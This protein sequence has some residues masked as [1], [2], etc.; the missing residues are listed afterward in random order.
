MCLKLVSLTLTAAQ[1]LFGAQAPDAWIV[2]VTASD[3]PCV[4]GYKV[5]PYKDLCPNLQLNTK[6][7][8]C[9]HVI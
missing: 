2:F 5:G 3:C 6:S 1:R 8:R 4:W 9:I 7:M